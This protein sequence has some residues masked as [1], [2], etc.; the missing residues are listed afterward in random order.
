[1]ND[2]DSAW[3]GGLVVF[4]DE[5]AVAA[6]WRILRAEKEHGLVLVYR[7]AQDLGHVSFLH[8]SGECFEVGVPVLC[9]HIT[10]EDL[11]GRAEGRDVLVLDLQEMF[12]DVA[13]V[14]L[15]GEAGKLGGVFQPDVDDLLYLV[16][17][18]ERN[19]VLQA[20]LR[21][22]HGVEGLHHRRLTR[23]WQYLKSSM[24]ATLNYPGIYNE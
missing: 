24:V 8:Q 19:E 3:V 14:V 21:V 22:A 9:F 2:G 10:G 4:R 7:L 18:Q 1:M 20:L 15:F 12:K 6:L 16:F 17:G 23:R 5:S 13:Q 11:L